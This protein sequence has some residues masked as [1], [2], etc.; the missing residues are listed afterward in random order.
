VPLGR[1]EL[2]LAPVLTLSFSTE[3]KGFG[4]ASARA[5]ARGLQRAQG[6]IHWPGCCVACFPNV[7]RGDHQI[8]TSRPA[9]TAF[10]TVYRV[11]P[12]S[13]RRFSP[14]HSICSFSIE[15]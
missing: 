1:L 7:I 12:V 8:Q 4:Q 15:N 14:S 13:L 11:L 2:N 10:S 5:A 9:T 3:I 6:E